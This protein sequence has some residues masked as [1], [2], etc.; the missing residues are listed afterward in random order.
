[1]WAAAKR[2]ASSAPSSVRTP[3]TA[4]GCLA[5]DANLRLRSHSTPSAYYLGVADY[6]A[7]TWHWQA[8]FAV[9]HAR[10]SLPDYEYTSALG[11][12]MAA[13]VAYNG[14]QFDLVGLGV[15]VRDD[16]DTEAPPPSRTRRRYRPTAG[17]CWW[18]G[19]GPSPAGN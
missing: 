6:P 5:A 16:A 11:N 2:Q 12:L 18:N 10:V 13:V 8:P 1:L 9:S 17:R 3:R 19:R 15:N 4:P 7:N 14:S